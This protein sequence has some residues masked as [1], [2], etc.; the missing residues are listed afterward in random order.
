[1]SAPE[2][3]VIGMSGAS[4][5]VYGIRLLE[6]LRAMGGVET[7]LV[8]SPAA[9]Q[10]I[11]SE[12]DLSVKDVEQL[13]DVVHGHRE[14]GATIASGSFRTRGMIVAPC[15]VKSLSAIAYGLAE[16]LIGRAADVHLKEGRPLVLLFRETPV[17]VGHIKAMLAAAENGAIIFPPLPAFYNRPQTVDDIV[18]DTV[19]RVLSR[20][21]LDAPVKA[22]AG[23]RAALKGEE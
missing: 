10:T 9:R 5:A 1:M 22:W 21:G 12:T 23:I 7:H 4:G 15:S 8:I 6:A 19:S 20:I 11:E 13:A 2:R 3:L 14:I 17:H 16:D 18:N